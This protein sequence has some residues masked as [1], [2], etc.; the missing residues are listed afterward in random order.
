MG[1][2]AR[3]SLSALPGHHRK[4]LCHRLQM[5]AAGASDARKTDSIQLGREDGADLCTQ[6]MCEHPCPKGLQTTTG[7]DI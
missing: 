3:Y 6:R 1:G 4:P 5:G 2:G 7:G